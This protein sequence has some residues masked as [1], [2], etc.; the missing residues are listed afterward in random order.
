MAYLGNLMRPCLKI[1]SFRKD[2][3]VVIHLPTLHK[4][5][6]SNPNTH[7]TP[8]PKK[9][10][11]KT[12]ERQEMVTAAYNLEMLFSHL[13]CVS[14]YRGYWKPNLSPL[15][16]WYVILSANPSLQHTLGTLPMLLP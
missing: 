4:V 6:G 9:N 14:L 8:P 13:P 2:S 10:L 16:E 11:T 7:P 3:S 15:Q 1:G 5:L 12:V